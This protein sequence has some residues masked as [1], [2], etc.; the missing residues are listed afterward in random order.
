MFSHKKKYYLI[1][2]SIKDINLNNIKKR[3]KFIVI[4]RNNENNEKLSNQERFDKKQISIPIHSALTDEDV[5]IV[6]SS[7]MKGW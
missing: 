4:Y 1:V 5:S 6:I 3:Y 7:I 2:E